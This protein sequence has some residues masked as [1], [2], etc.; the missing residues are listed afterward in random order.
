[1]SDRRRKDC[2]KHFRHSQIKKRDDEKLVLENGFGNET[3][4]MEST[5]FDVT[6][7]FMK[8]W[9]IW[10]YRNTENFKTM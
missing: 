8:W 3:N 4:V 5:G 10:L 7:Q 1:M 9:S 6:T 2:W